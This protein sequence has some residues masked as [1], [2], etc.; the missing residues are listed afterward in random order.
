MLNAG[1][2]CEV[3]PCLLHRLLSCVSAEEFLPM[4]PTL[5]IWGPQADAGSHLGWLFSPTNPEVRG[6][7]YSGKPQFTQ[8]SECALTWQLVQMCNVTS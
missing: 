1:V 3:P 7:H 6:E 8:T 5:G 4:P 2:C